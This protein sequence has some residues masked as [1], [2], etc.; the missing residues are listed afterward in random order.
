MP[1]YK[2]IQRSELRERYFNLQHF[3]PT[4]A[5]FSAADVDECY[6]ELVEKSENGIISKFAH[7]CYQSLLMFDPTEDR[8]EQG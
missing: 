5:N 4:R 3:Y 7:S 2:W 6:E 1:M 8:L